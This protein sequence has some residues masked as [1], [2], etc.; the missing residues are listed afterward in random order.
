MAGT[1]ALPTGR[2]R[3]RKKMGKL[4]TMGAA[5]TPMAAYDYVDIMGDQGMLLGQEVLRSLGLYKKGGKVGTGPKGCGA[6]MK[7]YG[8]AMK[9]K[10]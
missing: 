2:G 9:G 4:K 3:K 8:K 6:A 10:K 5:L 7:G 1:T